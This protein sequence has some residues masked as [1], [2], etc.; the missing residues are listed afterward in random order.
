MGFK[1]VPWFPGR[2]GWTYI[3]LGPCKKPLLP[4]SELLQSR[5]EPTKGI[6]RGPRTMAGVPYVTNPFW[7][8]QSALVHFKR[9]SG[10]TGGESTFVGKIHYHHR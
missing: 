6:R 9:S 3:R 10:E 2:L 8:D 1:R 7:C 4:V 5:E